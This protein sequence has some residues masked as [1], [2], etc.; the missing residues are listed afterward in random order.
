MTGTALFVGLST[1]DIAYLVQTYPQEDSKTRAVDQY[2]GAGGPAANAAVTYAFLSNQTS[3]LLTALGKHTLT[4][5]VRADLN[6]HNVKILNAASNGSSLPPISSIVIAKKSD[7]R[8]I[9]SL[10]TTRTQASF[11]DSFRSILHREVD[12][13]LTDGHYAELSMNIARDARKLGIPVLL[14]PGRWKDNFAEL[15]PLVDIAICSSA[16]SPPELGEASADAKLDFVHFLGPQ[17]VAI[18]RGPQPIL[19]RQVKDEVRRSLTKL[20]QWTR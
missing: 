9:F 20:Q 10:D 16:F 12:I 6:T 19:Y 3:T 18:T 1:L 8:T 13:V 11:H 15:L 5:L 2:I 14:D 7:S 4:E 17:S